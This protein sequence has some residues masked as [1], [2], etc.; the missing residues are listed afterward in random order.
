MSSKPITVEYIDP[1]DY[2]GVAPQPFVIVGTEPAGGGGGGGAVN[3]VAGRTG[4]VTLVK[5]DVGLGSVDNTSDAS[6]PVSAAQAA[7]LALKASTGDLDN[8]FAIANA[9]VPASRTVA[10][11]PLS[12]N[13]ALVKADVGLGSVDNTTDLAKP[14]STAVTT[15]LAGKAATG[16]SHTAAQITDFS[17][18]VDARVATLTARIVIVGSESEI[19][20]PA[21]PGVIY[22]VKVLA[23]P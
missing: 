11:K 3:S 20:D 7:A 1:A 18:A 21:T 5:A 16:H 15:A 22:A 4:T 9:A 8:V 12:S 2:V 6:K 23:A 10:G 14:L 17:A 19:P 13:I